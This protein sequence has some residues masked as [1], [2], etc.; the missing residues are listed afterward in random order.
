M[1]LIKWIITAAKNVAK[2]VSNIGAK[3]GKVIT[4][5]YDQLDVLGKVVVPV[6]VNVVQALKTYMNSGVSNVVETIIKIAIPGTTDDKIIDAVRKWLEDELPNIARELNLVSS[7]IN[8]QSTDMKVATI[9]DRLKLD[10]SQGAKCLEFATRL[11]FYLSDGK[12][13]MEELKAASE[14][15]YENFVKP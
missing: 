3:T 13:T 9:I 12:L 4:S 2:F 5:A 6:A 14:D 1:S 11:S 7:I 8:L 15:Y 10:Q